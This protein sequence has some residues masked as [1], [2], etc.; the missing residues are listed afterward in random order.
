MAITSTGVPETDPHTVISSF[1]TANLVSPDGVWTPVVNAKWL[2]HKKTKTYQIVVYPAYAESNAINLTGGA[3]TT[4]PTIATAYY[5][6]LLYS[7]S[8][9]N[10]W[11]LYRKAIDVLNNET[12]T[13]PQNGSGVYTGVA[14][15]D[16]HF[17][18][19]VRAEG[20]KTIAL[21]DELCGPGA[22]EKDDCMGYRADITVALRWN[23]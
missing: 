8:R 18:R 20:Q 4:M 15:S 11:K 12:V 21:N 17:I 10:L 5:N 9:T 19:I 6:I 3:S 16:Y 22:P 7:P 23:E 1:L 2:D 13:S 14:G